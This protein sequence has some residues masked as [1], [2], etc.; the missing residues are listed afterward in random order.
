MIFTRYSCSNCGYVT[1]NLSKMRVHASQKKHDAVKEVCSS[2][3]TIEVPMEMSNSSVK[4][5]RHLIE[6]E[7]F[8]ATQLEWECGE[9]DEYFIQWTR[10]TYGNLAPSKNRSIKVMKKHLKHPWIEF[11]TT[12]GTSEKLYR[13]CH[14]D[15]IR[16]VFDVFK[17]CHDV[18]RVL[19]I[20]ESVSLFKVNRLLIDHF[21]RFVRNGDIAR[22]SNLIDSG[23]IPQSLTNAFF[24]VL[25][26]KEST[27]IVMYTCRCGYKSYEKSATERHKRA[28]MCIGTI[29]IEKCQFSIDSAQPEKFSK[30]P[31]AISDKMFRSLPINDPDIF[32]QMDVD[33]L[34]GICECIFTEENETYGRR[35]DTFIQLCVLGEENGGNRG[36]SVV[37]S[38]RYIFIQR[39]D[40]VWQQTNSQV[41]RIALVRALKMMY[42]FACL[43]FCERIPEK[44]EFSKRDIHGGLMETDLN[45]FKVA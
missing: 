10:H 33:A 16:T 43:S 15:L 20:E 35:L 25:T 44:R 34:R 21:A 4:R 28:K 2:N 12:V 1:H 36:Q 23:R 30:L 41:N 8:E 19:M 26:V 6:G 40:R 31:P 27:E 38:S 24:S 5:D 29:K 45:V 39:A 7:P 14:S 11:T 13:K 37:I 3:E 17:K 42:K 22:L 32:D 18:E 9:L